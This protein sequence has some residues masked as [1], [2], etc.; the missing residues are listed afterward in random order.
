MDTH[1]AEQIM[2][3]GALRESM[4]RAALQV[5]LQKEFASLKGEA[6]QAVVGTKQEMHSLQAEL[7]ERVWALPGRLS[8]L[9]VHRSTAIL[10][11]AFVWARGALDSPNRRFLARADPQAADGVP[12]PGD[13]EDGGARGEDHRA[14]GSIA[15]AQRPP[16]RICASSA[17]PSHRRRCGGRRIRRAPSASSCRRATAGSGR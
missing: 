11:S 12:G 13:A 9:S 14:G 15:P 3:L 5:V 2:A 6:E 17:R 1:R 10:C 8:A 16:A 7:G 4:T